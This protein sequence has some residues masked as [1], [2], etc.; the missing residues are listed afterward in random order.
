MENIKPIIELE[1]YIIRHGESIGNA[2]FGGKTDLTMRESVDPVLTEKGINQAIAAGEFL[3]GINLNAV[4]SSALMRAVRT[5]GEIIKNN[6]K[7]KHSLFILC[8]PKWEFLRNIMPYQWKNY[9][10]FVRQLLSLTEL[11]LN[12]AS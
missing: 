9:I 1:L 11:T 4:Y 12:H 7:K 10:S 3:S 2:G 8:S 6:L 5:A